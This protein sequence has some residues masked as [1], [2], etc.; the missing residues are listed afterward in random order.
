MNYNIVDI[1]SLKF[2]VSPLKSLL[3]DDLKRKIGNR[4]NS[5]IPV[6]R[7][8]GP[9]QIIID[10]QR[11]AARAKIYQPVVPISL[12]TFWTAQTL[13]ETVSPRQQNHLNHIYKIGLISINYQ[14]LIVK[15][16]QTRQG[17]SGYKIKTL[18][19]RPRP[20]T[21]QGNQF[22]W[23]PFQF[24]FYYFLAARENNRPPR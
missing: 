10:E 8:P 20:K 24:P 2:Q 16:V 4:S 7:R 19:L 12:L 13:N 1:F 18:R 11:R 6:E 9:G 17:L 3:R 23:N 5:S 14:R 15:A 22:P 21:R